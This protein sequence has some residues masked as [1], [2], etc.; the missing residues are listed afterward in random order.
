MSDFIFRVASVKLTAAQQQQI[1]TAI[2]GAV[3]TELAKLDLG[4]SSAASGSPAQANVS[5]SG[6]DFLYRPNK[7]YGGIMLPPG[8]VA[9]A[10]KTT[11]SV[12]Q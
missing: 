11:L 10:G 3:L 9:S 8:E 6:G 12:A 1:A 7:W 5:G 4:G 2:Q